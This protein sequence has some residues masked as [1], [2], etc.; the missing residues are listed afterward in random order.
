MRSRLRL[1]VLVGLAASLVDFG[2]L[3]GLAP[4][5]VVPADLVALAAAS[6]TSYL[7]NR[8]ITFRGDPAA[9]WVRRPSLF[10]AVAVV[11]GLVDLAV[12]A[13]LAAVGVPLVAAKTVAVVAAALIRWTAYRRVL[14]TEVRR[15]LARRRPRPPVTGDV[16]LTVVIPAYWEGER[17]GSTVAAVTRAVTDPDADLTGP[18]V[19]PDEVEIIV[20]DDGSGDET[21]ARAA[22]AGATVV[23]Q[24]V[25]R[26]KGAAVRAGVLAARGRTVV[27][28]DADLAYPPSLILDVLAT[29]EGGWDVAVGSRRHTETNTLVRARRVRELGGRVINLWTHLVLLG[30]FHDTQ[31]GIK[32]FR[33]DVG[34]AVFER[35]RIDGFAFDVE[36]FLMAE[37]DRLSLTEIPVSV[38]NRPGSSVSVVGDSLTVLRDLVRIR[39]WAGAGAYRPNEQQGAVV[40][41]TDLRRD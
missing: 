35:S 29:V 17:I 25:N 16:R 7:G 18:R 13:G 41:E 2:L 37:Q 24:P 20:V 8:I 3:L 19:H 5:G 28:T 39:R 32:G 15:E 1:F 21:A 31:C 36:L 40:G 38:R 34:V 27:F 14:F 30:A 11:A 10:A 6:L 4:W 26:G 12:V 23:R 9:R 22:A 33:R